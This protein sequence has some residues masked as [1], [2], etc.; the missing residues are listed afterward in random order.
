MSEDGRP[1]RYAG[2]QWSRPAIRSA[3][4]QPKEPYG[5]YTM[6][7]PATR[8][9][10]RRRIILCCSVLGTLY[11]VFLGW[12]YLAG[13]EA[14]LPTLFLYGPR[15]MAA[16]P[17]IVLGPV[18]IVSRSWFLLLVT[19]LLGLIIVGPLT[20]GNLG[21]GPLFERSS[22]ALQ[23][24][25]VVTWNMGGVRRGPA[26][27]RFIEDLDPT[28]L[29]CQES[30]LLEED[31]PK[32]WKLIANGGNRIAT[33]LAVRTDGSFN[34]APIGAPGVVDR[35]LVETPNGTLVLVNVHLPTPR[36]GIESAVTSKG[37]DLTELGRIIE[38]RA[39]A[40]RAARRWIHERTGSMI[41]AG[42]FNM[43]VESRIYRET[44]SSLENSFTRAGQGWGTTKQ[45]SWFGSRIDHV[46]Y[47]APW[48]C[49]S[50]WTGPAM[51]SDHR[52]LIADL[53]SAEPL[54]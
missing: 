52:P 42:D 21:L 27:R 19:I 8:P 24:L 12:L 31:L 1:I 47:S 51:G 49:R 4:H 20:G 7:R 54:D 46:L 15:W 17:L 41:V 14:A 44:W 18:A 25:R 6:E 34:L 16:L 13:D 35:Y 43:T 10:R 3:H 45:T 36:P 37:L 2:P 5:P 40:S 22:P 33:R 39:E 9:I 28:I 26:I 48:R 23:K 53:E 30:D 32:G 38:I 29:V 50:A 11:G